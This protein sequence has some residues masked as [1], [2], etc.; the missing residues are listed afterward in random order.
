MPKG[1]SA[2]ELGVITV[3]QRHA[4]ILQLVGKLHHLGAP[5]ALFANHPTPLSIPCPLLHVACGGTALVLWCD[6]CPFSQVL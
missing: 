5:C 1:Y 3:R 4:V 6:L 2:R